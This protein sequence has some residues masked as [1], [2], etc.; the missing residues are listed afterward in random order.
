MG[1]SGS[2]STTA[3]STDSVQDSEPP[4]TE[5]QVSLASLGI[6]LPKEPGDVFIAGR[7]PTEV[8]GTFAKECGSWLCILSAKERTASDVAFEEAAVKAGVQW[9]NADFPHPAPTTEQARVILARLE[10]MPRPLIV[11]CASG[12]RAGAVLLLWVALRRGCS[13]ASASQ[14]ASDMD[15]KFFTQ[16]TSCG[17]MK[18]WVLGHLPDDLSSL[19]PSPSS[20][21]SALVFQQLFDPTSS[22]LTYLIGCPITGKALLIDAVLEQVN[23]DLSVIDEL[24]FSLVYV[25]STHVHADHVTSGSVIRHRRP[26]VKTIISQGSGAAADIKVQHGDCITVG[27]L[28]LEVRATPGHTQGC[29]SYILN[30]PQGGPA[31]AFTGDTVLI[32]GC[33]RTDFQGGNAE[34]LYDSVHREIFSLPET[35]LI[36][37][38]HDYRGRNVSS[39]REEV[40]YNPRL[41]KPK[42]E[43]VKIMAELN[44]PYPK[45]LAVAVPANMV[46]G[47]FEIMT[48]V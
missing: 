33:G 22:T 44:L 6:V 42:Q 48:R 39:V 15:L 8:L 38:A 10:D 36:Y 40:L 27:M 4:V 19:A 25:I 17:P 14:L 45:Q 26:A 32:R 20:T 3:V 35:T 30:P 18:E 31:M 11:S 24:G 34:Q 28:T 5:S 21:P 41:S 37:P 43:F 16:C 1:C 12:N 9:V 7:V 13:R 29:V 2:R 47:C 46:C 23:R